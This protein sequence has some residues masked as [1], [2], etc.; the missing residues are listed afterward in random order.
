[1]TI[2]T[3]P[4]DVLESAARRT[5]A[6]LT[7]YGVISSWSMGACGMHFGATHGG[8]EISILVPWSEITQ[9]YLPGELLHKTE[10]AALAGLS[11]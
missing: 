10:R 8:S 4:I 7:D 11:T 6:Y 1:M 2:P 3:I 5:D 9:A